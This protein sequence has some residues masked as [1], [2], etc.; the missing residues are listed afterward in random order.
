[1]KILVLNAGSSSQKSC[2]YQIP[3]DQIPEHPLE[4]LWKADIDW[5]TSADYGMLTVKANGV[6]QEIKIPS[7]NR[8]V[9]V[10][11]LLDTLVQGDTK[12]IENLSEIQG[13]GHRIV[14]GGKKYSEA[15]LI[16]P[17]VKQEIETLIPLAPAHNSAHLDGIAAIERAL[18]DVPQV[19]VFDTAFHTSMPLETS[20]YPL[21]YEWSEKGIRRYGFH[22]TSHQYC[23]YR[24]AQILGKP[25]T[26]LKIISCHLGNGCSLTAIKEGKSI[27]TT[28]GFTPLE[29][30]MMGTRSGSFDPGILIYIMREHLYDIEQLNTL[31]NQESGLKGISGISGDLRPVLQAME[32]GNERAKLAFNMYI[33]RIKEGIGEMLSS[34]EGVDVLL[35]TAGVGENAA[36]V[37]EKV[38]EG[39]GFL[40]WK[41]DQNKNNSRPVDQ[42]IATSDSTIRILVIHTE[43]DWAIARETWHKIH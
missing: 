30:L 29:G 43:E 13:V 2:L 26:S 32:Q 14:H 28:M 15:T 33:R 25:I 21:P 19:A 34:L 36:I 41:I 16:T 40:G 9:G 12:V 11:K 39:Y 27:N 8:S 20:I 35:F 42:D 24:A 6:K 4:P 18:K 31:L 5:T 17:D 37:R 3:D 7:D 1:M 10:V 23:A 22:G 38:C